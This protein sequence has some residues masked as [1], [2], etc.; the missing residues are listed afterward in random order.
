[1]IKATLETGDAEQ[2]A[3]DPAL[4]P[5]RP[6][7]TKAAADNAAANRFLRDLQVQMQK[8]GPVGPTDKNDA[9]MLD[10]RC[11]QSDA[12]KWCETHFP[13]MGKGHR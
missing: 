12:P 9:R 11:S 7:V 4:H 8:H 1:M 2:R 13:S 10:E 5:G 6:S 3:E